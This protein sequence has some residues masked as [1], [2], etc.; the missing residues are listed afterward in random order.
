MTLIIDPLISNCSSK[1]AR[2]AIQIFQ[3]AV[4]QGK[5]PSMLGR[6]LYLQ[7]KLKEFTP[8]HN[9]T[10]TRTFE[11]ESECQVVRVVLT[12]P[13]PR[14]Q[15][16]YRFPPI[17][18]DEDLLHPN[19]QPSTS[20]G[21]WDDL[22]ET[23]LEEK[24]IAGD[25]EEEDATCGKL[26]ADNFAYKSDSERMQVKSMNF[27]DKLDIQDGW[28]EHEIVIGEVKDEKQWGSADAKIPWLQ[29][30]QC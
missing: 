17:I 24:T 12:P 27:Y 2:E 22:E 20:G 19:W 6:K 26:P 8:R 13:S 30:S 4:A 21:C 3:Q 23:F 28:N 7:S 18:I 15:S 9:Q 5:Q 29:E 14:G 11:I 16:I 10:V 25:S 1:T